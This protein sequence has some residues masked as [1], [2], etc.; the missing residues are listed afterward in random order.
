MAA[1]SKKKA[2]AAKPVARRFKV[3]VPERIT[4]AFDTTRATW[5]NETTNAQLR[6]WKGSEHEL[7]AR[8]CRLSGFTPDRIVHQG[9][10]LLAQRLIA[11]AL[12]DAHLTVTRGGVRGAADERLAAGYK[13][14]KSAGL[15]DADIT[16]SRLGYACTPKVN[17]RTATTW[18]ANR[19]L[20][21]SSAA[22]DAKATDD[23]R[24]TIERL[25]TERAQI[26]AEIRLLSARLG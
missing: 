24:A 19:G 10:Q 18:L 11:T 3:A 16:A 14:L 20:L 13:A 15:A 25:T 8:A 12:S 1:S 7:L 17:Y 2:P 26:E 4:I 6:G 22:K 5:F 9:M 23:D 21:A